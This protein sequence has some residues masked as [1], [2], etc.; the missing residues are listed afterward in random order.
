MYV[1]IG[2]A[3]VLI[4]VVFLPDLFTKNNKQEEENGK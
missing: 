3:M 4:G 1:A 2:V